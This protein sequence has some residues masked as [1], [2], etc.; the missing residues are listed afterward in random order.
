MQCDQPCNDCCLHAD[1]TA[2]RQPGARRLGMREGLGQTK[3]RTLDAVGRMLHD[4]GDI[5]AKNAKLGKSR[6]QKRGI[7]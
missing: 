5:A 6:Q 2:C 4:Y 3:P 1:L 7:R